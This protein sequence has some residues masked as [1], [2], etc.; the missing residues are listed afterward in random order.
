MM[1]LLEETAEAKQIHLEMNFPF[2][3][4]RKVR[5]EEFWAFFS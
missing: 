3:I 2:S 4:H 1:S 5:D